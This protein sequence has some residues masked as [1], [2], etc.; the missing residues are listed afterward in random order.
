MKKITDTPALSDVKVVGLVNGCRHCVSSGDGY[1]VFYED[2]T[3][4]PKPLKIAK[5][6]FSS[7]AFT[8]SDVETAD[9]LEMVNATLTTGT[10]CTNPVTWHI[11]KFRHN[12][13]RNGSRVASDLYFIF[14]SIW[15]YGTEFIGWT[16][17]AAAHPSFPLV[18]NNL[19]REITM[20][21]Q[22][23]TDL[24]TV[25]YN[26]NHDHAYVPDPAGNDNWKILE[27]G[28]SGDCEDFALTK[29]QALLNL[30]YDA[31]ALHI[32][33]SQIANPVSG[34]RTGH[35]WLVV[36][37]TTGDY[38]LDVNSD[39]VG[40]NAALTFGGKEFYTRKRQIGMNWA[41]IS[42]FSPFSYIVNEPIGYY[43][44]YIYDPLL[45]IMYP[46]PW[47]IN[48]ADTLDKPFSEPSSYAASEQPGDEYKNPGSPSI[49]F[50]VDNNSI[51]YANNGTLYTLRLDE[52][53]LTTV[54][55]STYTT[56]GF[57][58]R[59]GTIVAGIDGQ[60]NFDP[61]PWPWAYWN[62]IRAEVTSPEG[63]YDFRYEYYMWTM[64]SYPIPP[65][66]H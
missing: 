45:N 55:S 12:V 21:A 58:N 66:Q 28:Q 53:V 24:Q 64:G 14:T 7:S 39:S 33:C 54:S 11:K 29:A 23:M 5:C 31:A 51:Y 20:T 4:S 37:T 48:D 63:Y 16:N 17:F 56:N 32:E 47:D 44:S 2:A 6:N 50:S 1:F 43:F 60:A 34:T 36:Q 18:T 26:V 27:S 46:L 40:I 38:A 42:P 49:N 8:A 30:G 41:F 25:N 65:F 3:I 62:L 15:F 59:A 35:A 13:L 22:L 9:S 19:N 52:N 57:V 10:P 61:Y